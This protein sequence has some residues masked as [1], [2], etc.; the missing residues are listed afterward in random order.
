M[1]LFGKK[2]QWRIV[3][4]HRNGYR[5]VI[6]S[7]ATQQEAEAHLPNFETVRDR[8]PNNVFNQ[9]KLFISYE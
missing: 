6:Q 7:Y 3:F 2:E 5:Q 4:E 8:D 9:G 1:G